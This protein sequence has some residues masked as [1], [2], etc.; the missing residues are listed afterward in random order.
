MHERVPGGA[1][2]DVRGLHDLQRGGRAR[3]NRQAL[4]LQ[5]GAV[6]GSSLTGEGFMKA[7]ATI[8]SEAAA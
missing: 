6:S 4:G 5:V 8:E 1:G 2:G 7:L 3:R